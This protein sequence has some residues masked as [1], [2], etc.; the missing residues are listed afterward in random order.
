MDKKSDAEPIAIVGM[1]CRWPGGVD[2]P[3]R[4]WSFLRDGS[5]GFRPFDSSS[6]SRCFT[7]SGF[8]HPDPGR[9]GTTATEGAFLVDSDPRLFDHT[10]FGITKREAETLDPSQ[11]KLLEVAYEAFENAAV[12]AVA[13]SKPANSITVD[14]ACSSSLHAVHL[15]VTA[16]RNGECESAIVATSNWISD[17]SLHMAL[18]KL[19]ALS[20]TSRCHTFDASADGYARGEGFAAI[21]LKRLLIALTDSSPIRGVIRG[22]AVNANGRTGGI[23]RPSAD[24]QE[25]AIRRAYANAG[26][27]FSDTTYVECHGTGTPAGDPIEL[28]AIGRAFAS[29]RDS[30][31]DGTQPLLVGSVKTN[32]GH[33]EGASGLAGIMKVVLSLEACE[34]PPSIGIENLNPNIDFAGAGIEVVRQVTAWPQHR[35]LRASISSFGLGGSNGHVIIEHASILAP[36]YKSPRSNYGVRKYGTLNGHL[37]G[38]NGD[39]A[40]KITCAPG[41]SDRNHHGTEAWIRA[42]QP[43]QPIV[44]PL[45]MTGVTNATTRRLVLLPFSAHNESS[46]EQNINALS[47]VLHQDSIADVTYTLGTK[48]SSFPYKSFRIVD[49]SISNPSLLGINSKLGFRPSLNY[50]QTGNL[51]FIFTGQAAQWHGMGMEL[52]EYRVF[53]AVIEYL[54]NILRALPTPPSTW[55]IF[56]VIKG[57]C[58]PDLIQSPSVSLTV[59][60]AIQIGLIDLLAS[61]SIRPI[62]VAGHSSGEIAAAYASG[63]ITAADAI[64]A[65]YLRGIAASKNKKKGVMLAVALGPD[66]L[67]DSGYL[68]D[69]ATEHGKLQIAAINSPQSITVSGDAS[70]IEALATRLASDGVFH[71][72]LKTGGMAY[73]SHHMVALGETYEETLSYGFQHIRKLGLVDERHRYPH[74]PWVSSVTPDKDPLLGIAGGAAYWRANLELPVRF[75]EAVSKLVELDENPVRAIIEVGPHSTLKGPLEQILKSLGKTQIAYAGST[76]KRGEDA[77][78][79]MLQLAGALYCLNSTIDMVAVNSIDSEEDTYDLVHGRTAVDLPPYQYTYGPIN[80]Y[81]CRA[82]KEYRL[83]KVIRHDLLG[84]KVPGVAKLRPQWRNVLR[85]KDLPWLSDHRLLPDIVFPAA[86]YIAM[87]IEAVLRIYE[88]TP[89]PRPKITGYALR[90]VSIKTALRIPDDEQGIETVLSIELIDAMPTTSWVNFTISSV[91]AQAD[92]ID[93]TWTEHCTGSVKI[94]FGSLSVDTE[95]IDTSGMDA[96]VI[97]VQSWYKTFAAI[98]LG[99]GP[100]FRPL[101]N[102]RADPDKKLASATVALNTTTGT[103]KGGESRYVI[104]PTALDAAF[105]LGLIA[106]YGGRVEAATTAFVPVH[107]SRL[108]IKDSISGGS[109]DTAQAIAL[110]EI[111]GL[112]GAYI[113][114]LQVLGPDGDV[115][116]NIEKLRN[117]SYFGGSDIYHRTKRD[118]HSAFSAPFTRVVWKP[119]FRSLNSRS[120]RVLFPPPRE[121]LDRVMVVEKLNVLA[122]V[123]LADIYGMFTKKNADHTSIPMPSG[124]TGHFVAWVKRSVEEGNNS[125]IAKA[126]VVSVEERHE[127]ISELY[128]ET[129]DIIEARMAK[130]LH[131]NMADIISE[132]RTGVDV[133]VHGDGDDN[134][135]SALY[136][137]GLFMTSAYPQ[138]SRVIDGLAHVNPHLRILEVGAGTGGATRV[139]LRTLTGP[140]HIKRYR[141]YA[142]TDISP[143][144]LAVGQTAMAEFR[145]IRYSVLNIEVDPA[146]QGYESIYDVVVASQALHATASIS[147]T[148]KN[149]RKLL[150]PGGKLILIESTVENSE[151]TG[152]ILGT[153]T[154][155]WDGMDDGRVNSPFMSL[156]RW[157]KALRE[158]G[159]SGAEL[160]LD[161]YPKPNSMNATLV[162]TLI[163]NSDEEQKNKALSTASR[164]IEVQMLHSLKYNPP[165]LVKLHQELERR[166]ISPQSA[167]LDRAPSVVSPG[168]HVVVVLES[169][170][171]FLLDIQGRHLATFQHI[172]RTAATLICLTFCGFSNGQNPEGAIIPGLLRT[173]GTENPAGR[174]ISIDISENPNPAAFDS[175]DLVRCLADKLL[176]TPYE[177]KHREEDSRSPTMGDNE[178]VWRNGCLWVSRIVPDDTLRPYTEPSVRNSQEECTDLLVSRPLDSQ[179]PVR[180]AFS[181]PGILSSLY[182]Q[183]YTELLAPIP[184]NYID[185][186]VAA[187]GINWKDLAI[188][189][190]RF[191]ANNLSSE[192]SG[193]V[194]TVGADAVDRFS[195]GDRV[196]GMGRGHFGNYTRVQAAFAQKLN[197]QDD[198]VEVATMPLVYM[199]AVY[200]FDYAARLRRGQRVLIQSAS[201]GLGLAAI[202]LARSKGAEVFA[203]VGS[204]EKA[205]FLV[206]EMKMPESHVISI[207]SRDKTSALDKKFLSM[208]P[209][210]RGFDIILSTSRGDVLHASVQALAPL[211]HLVDVGRTDVQ[212]S[213]ALSMDLFSKGASFS[214]FDLSLV[215]DA[216]P[217]LGSELMQTVHSYYRNGLIGPVRPFSATDVSKLDQV[218]LRFSKGTH[219]GKLVVTFQDPQ[220]LVRMLPPPSRHEVRF[221]P[222]A[223]YIIIGGFGGLGRSII[224]WMCQR[225]ARK[226]AILSRR[227]I[228]R[229][230][231]AAKNLISKLTEDG[232][233]I[234]SFRC[235]ISDES[236]VVQIIRD[237]SFVFPNAP[238]KGII[239]AAASY[240]D[241]S[242]DKLGVSRWRDSLAAKVQ[243][244]KNLHKA[245][246]SLRSEQLDFFIMITSL[247]SVYAL[248]TQSAYTAANAFQDAFARYRRRLGMPATSI[249][250]GF[251]NE[252]GDLSQD[253]ITVDMFARN[254]TLTLSEVQFLARLEAAF[255]NG[256]MGGSESDGDKWIGQTDDP[257]SASNILTCLDPASMAA[258]QRDEE[259]EVSKPAPSRPVRSVI[260]RWYSDPRVSLIM[261]AF[262][263]AR[264]NVDTGKS[265]DA[266]RG[267]GDGED[268]I[269]KSSVRRIRREF[270]SAIAAGTMERLRTV[271]FVTNATT[272]AVA[273]TLF[274]DVSTVN[275][276]RSVAEHGVDSLIAAEL[277]NWFHQALEANITMQELLDAKT[278][279]AVLAGKIV[280]AALTKRQNKQEGRISI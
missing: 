86:G 166:G 222:T 268:D 200:A 195:I 110:G 246:L 279:I 226:L 18:D 196:Y 163:E 134:L 5:S 225:G 250:F 217:T 33:A 262:E 35:P 128:L 167:Q 61:W 235:D 67:R 175:E 213:K 165:L 174:F 147:Q 1:G 214:S 71:R 49:T 96:R 68:H 198:L 185:V 144:F 240:L 60:T 16:I 177:N 129:E 52:F 70:A 257:L 54:D 10:F 127:K 64:V 180:A 112:R 140:N 277:R 223:H 132:R 98:G 169:E 40:A 106:C 15:A 50:H 46:L 232:I 263:D 119:D 151:I 237:I 197:M 34:I 56:D 75:S 73:H 36:N 17:P 121:N 194:T 126:R 260:P 120:C 104:H 157:D 192:Y 274:V 2:S 189:S 258:K 149:C 227:G 21:Y 183:A 173:I 202:Q 239:H 219:V 93:S 276:A 138:L 145:D 241:L 7:A 193:I 55:S 41:N 256:G 171:D 224:R 218:L 141:E 42:E 247:E 278:S 270:E 251:I 3:R 190:G 254:R 95:G 82:S 6:T 83:R 207:S 65:A 158:A 212:D 187:V 116:L 178:Y 72:L 44:K 152:L 153:L 19:G 12:Y 280:D 209:Q 43:H 266:T 265:S 234:Q 38:T 191:D 184:S 103:V 275:P 118:L 142:F 182:F 203:M 84:S 85:V 80:Y 11:R 255:L 155:Y 78:V 14:T 220:T 252:I 243:G 259:A 162:S 31:A 115:V 269:G 37:N 204:I 13:E 94:E 160:V 74:I 81:E 108:Y 53:R 245:T 47:Q 211:G 76:L 161:D 45:N 206:H 139:A 210:G 79:S 105:Q 181:T 164:G 32:M 133:I 109:Q 39:E 261:R 22:S 238:L 137:H 27:P 267:D 215:L 101:A 272:T 125:K 170:E 66:E 271:E 233:G 8:H 248:A 143:G 100:T 28:A 30:I 242:F 159:F 176:P 122:S 9:P 264:R 253:S 236:Q 208:T 25:A 111:R 117:I 136:Q 172:A 221:D 124:T 114:Q 146:T 89:E 88:E 59:C 29:D 62:A 188:S 77:C 90:N 123:I 87:A 48:R 205:Q 150:R 69:E 231:S 229:S 244:T 230:C 199:T 148:L 92:T 102:I 201:G 113:N 154:G 24:G 26:L 273:E 135:L 4:M 57:I 156:G 107:I 63:N 249:S 130:R 51:A 179:G 186:K 99:Y 58:D 20:P 168:A 228:E 91:D 97:D 216:D 131:E 23:T